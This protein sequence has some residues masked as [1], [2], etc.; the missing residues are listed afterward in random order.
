[1][2]ISHIDSSSF[3][4][5][6]ARKEFL[7]FFH[8]IPISTSFHIKLVSYRTDLLFTRDRFHFL[9]ELPPVNTRTHHSDRLLTVFAFSNKKP[10]QVA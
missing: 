3:V 6:M 5:L 4:W 8:M 2:V 10:L 7:G 9:T 1:M